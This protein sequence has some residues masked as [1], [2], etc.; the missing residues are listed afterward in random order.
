MKRWIKKIIVRIREGYLKEIY[1]ETVW[2]YQYVKRYWF[3]ICF[4]ILAGIFGTVMG[5]GSSVVSKYLIDAVTGVRKDKILLFAVLIICMTAAGIISNAVISRIS[6]R[7]NVVIQNEIQADIF[8]KLLY[9]EWKE[10]QQFRSGDLLNRLSND[11]VQVASSVISW[12]P[13]AGAIYWCICDYFL[14]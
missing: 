3:S 9:T 4:Y 10:L 2:M 14:L 6:A 11:A 13:K 7:I 1:K 5:L 8:Q 12:I